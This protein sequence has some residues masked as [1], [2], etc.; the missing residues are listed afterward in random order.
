[1][2][3]NNGILEDGKTGIKIRTNSAF[4]SQYSI[5]PPFH[6]SSGNLAAKPMPLG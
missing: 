1:M 3:W 6:Y 2:T 5:I 4:K